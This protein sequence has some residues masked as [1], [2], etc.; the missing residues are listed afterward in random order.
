MMLNIIF[1]CFLAIPVS[2]LEKYLWN[3]LPVLNGLFVLLLLLSFRSSLCTLDS[4]LYQIYHFSSS[5]SC[6]AH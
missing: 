1:M 2:S 6:W 5:V 4:I 3:P